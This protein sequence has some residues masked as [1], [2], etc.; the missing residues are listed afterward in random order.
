MPSRLQFNDREWCVCGSS[1]VSCY[2]NA[3]TPIPVGWLATQIQEHQCTTTI[4]LWQLHNPG[5]C[6]QQHTQRAWLTI[7][8]PGS[9]TPQCRTCHH[10]RSR[11]IISS[12]ATNHTA[13]RPSQQVKP[14]S[15]WTKPSHI[16]SSKPQPASSWALHT[17]LLCEGDEF[18]GLGLQTLK[19]QQKTTLTVCGRKNRCGWT[20]G[21]YAAHTVCCIHVKPEHTLCAQA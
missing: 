5:N 6:T 17:D 19:S 12:T 18:G 13:K 1:I 16:T 11:E 8:W 2:R 20:Q 14:Y 7:V 4:C 10:S 21:M 15:G 9:H 3:D